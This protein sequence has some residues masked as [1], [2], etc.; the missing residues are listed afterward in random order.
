MRM[1]PTLTQDDIKK[2]MAACEAEAV[3]NKWNVSIAIVDDGGFLLNLMRMDG[4]GPMTAEVS[5][6]KARTSALSRRPSRFWEERIKD[7]MVFLKFPE[8]L[9]ITGG[10]PI[11]VNGECVGAIGVSGVQSDEDEQIAIAGAK[12]IIN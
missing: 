3:R 1:R 2:A 5:M 9:P 4:T 8:N 12:A 6:Q 10:V 11:T 7:R